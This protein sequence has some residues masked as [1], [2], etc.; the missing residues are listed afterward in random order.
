MN[1]VILYVEDNPNNMRLVR[2][3]LEIEGYKIFGAQ[4]GYTGIEAALYYQ[5]DVILMDIDLPDMDGMEV[6]ARLRA[7]PQFA[8]T[9]IIALT[10]SAMDGDRERFTRGGCDGYV[11]KPITRN[12]LINAIQRCLL[13]RQS[14]SV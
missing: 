12:E 1:T 2:K 4:D 9:P 5:P 13:L 14:A 7:M 8:N 3:M 6:T 11:A 10:A